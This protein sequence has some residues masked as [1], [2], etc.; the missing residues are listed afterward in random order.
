MELGVEVDRLDSD[1]VDILACGFSGGAAGLP[2]PQPSH[3][4]QQQ[5]R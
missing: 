4:C 2:V 3:T 1:E 5:T